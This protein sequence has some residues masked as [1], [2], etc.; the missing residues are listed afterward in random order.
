MTGI[1]RRERTAIG[2]PHRGKLCRDEIVFALKKK[3][4]LGTEP[5]RGQ[6]DNEK[7]RGIRCFYQNENVHQNVSAATQGERAC[8]A[9]GH[10]ERLAPR[11][12]PNRKRVFVRCGGG[13]FWGVDKCP[14]LPPHF[15]APS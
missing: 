15:A 6:D 1:I 11:T 9:G 12:L 7:K 2:H 5:K 8:C 3:G 4:P 10:V 13:G 14:T